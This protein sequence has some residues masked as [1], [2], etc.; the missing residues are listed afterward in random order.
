MVTGCRLT[1]VLTLRWDD[2]DR[3]AGELRLREAKTGARMVALTPAALRVL[4]E[5]RRVPRSPWVFAGSTPERHLSNLTK[6]WHQVR[7]R[8]GVRGE[9]TTGVD[10]PAGRFLDLRPSP[11][12]TSL[13][14]E[15]GEHRHA[16]HPRTA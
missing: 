12:P 8:E 16:P 1:E 5:L 6:Y 10:P 11:S 3:K 4:S 7:A 14:G 2:V 15:R 9:G 13:P